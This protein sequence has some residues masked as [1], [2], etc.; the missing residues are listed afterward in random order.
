MTS[1][2]FNHTEVYFGEK[3]QSKW[4]KKRNKW[5][6]KK[7]NHVIIKKQFRKDTRR[8]SI[9]AYSYAINSSSITRKWKKD[10]I[11]CSEQEN[12]K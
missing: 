8:L 9:A 11:F 7:K 1:P 4:E 12:T 6:Q 2:K 10:Y 3:N 5:L